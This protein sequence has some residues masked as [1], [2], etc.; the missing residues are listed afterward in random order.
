MPG[1]R[2][3]LLL[4]VHVGIRLSLNRRQESVGA[5]GAKFALIRDLPWTNGQRTILCGMCVTANL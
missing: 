2:L 5:D 4:L 3:V 1:N